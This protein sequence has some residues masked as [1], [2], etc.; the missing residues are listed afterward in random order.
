MCL[1]ASCMSSFEKYLFRF[2]SIF[3]LGCFSGTDL[4]ELLVFFGDNPLSV[5]LFAIVFSCSEDC[6]LVIVSFFV[7]KLLSLIKSH[8]FTFV[9]VS[10]TLGG[11]S[12]GSCL[13]V[14]QRVYYIY[15]PL[16]AL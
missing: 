7:Q 4:H 10:V 11:G 5:V 14:C 2:L 9:F 16:S 12:K 1:L 13:L 8:L 6:L 3:W 15:F